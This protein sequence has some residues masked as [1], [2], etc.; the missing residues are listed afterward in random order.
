MGTFA[1]LPALR[2]TP[3]PPHHYSSVGSAECDPCD[4][5][6]SIVVSGGAECQVCEAGTQAESGV[7]EPC[8][9]GHAS[10]Y[11]E[12]CEACPRG[13]AQPLEAQPRCEPCAA[14]TYAN[15]EQTEC[16]ACARGTTGPAKCRPDATC[17]AMSSA[18]I[19]IGGKLMS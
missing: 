7:C 18:T 9:E 16:V 8:A 4:P 11:G 12:R 10:G 17:V 2:C 6:T 13:K 15:A 5:S 1:E 3:C 14:G 19:R